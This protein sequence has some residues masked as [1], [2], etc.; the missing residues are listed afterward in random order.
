M[1]E[2]RKGNLFDNL[3]ARGISE[4]CRDLFVSGGVRIER[5]VSRGHVSP[6]GFWYEQKTG[7]WVA[8]LGGEALLEWEDGRS[9]RMKA[10]EWVYLPP[11]ERHRVA[12]T[13]P[14]QP[15]VWLAVFVQ[16]PGTEESPQPRG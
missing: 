13:A 2:S 1:R 14:G 11:L 5:I 8:V 4:D 12:W 16:N 6:P 7:E 3:E 10:G 9:L 15:T